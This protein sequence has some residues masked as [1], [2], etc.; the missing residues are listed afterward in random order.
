M[1]MMKKIEFPQVQIVRFDKRDIIATSVS[2]PGM[3]EDM[4]EG[5]ADAPA[6]GVF[7]TTF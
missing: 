5:E 6:R 4:P 7:N 1:T 3:G 2:G